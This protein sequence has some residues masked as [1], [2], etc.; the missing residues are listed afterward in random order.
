[1]KNKRFLQRLGF[2]ANGIKAT[3]STEASFRFH[4]LAATYGELL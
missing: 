4:C 2:A 1:M 3:F